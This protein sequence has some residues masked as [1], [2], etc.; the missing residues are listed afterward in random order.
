[1]SEATYQSLWSEKKPKLMSNTGEQ[2]KVKGAISVNAQYKGQD[3]QLSLVV[4]NGSCSSV[5]ERD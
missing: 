4:V 3:H 2:I 1:M 5:L